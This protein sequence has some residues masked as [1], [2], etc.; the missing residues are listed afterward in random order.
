MI[1]CIISLMN[2]TDRL[3]EM[4]PSWTKIDK[5]KDF[6]IVDWC[7]KEPI[8]N[9]KIVQENLQKHNIKIIRVENENYFYRCQAWN[10]AF[11]YT[12]PENKILLKLDVDYVNINHSWLDCLKINNNELFDYFITGCYE[13]YPHS[14]GFLLINKKDFNKGYNENALPLWGF[15]DIDLIRRVQNDFKESQLSKYREWS[16]LQRVIFFNISQHI[17]HLPHSDKERLE[18]LGLY[19]SIL[20]KKIDKW[21]LALK[22][23]N[24]IKENPKWNPSEY[25]TLEESNNY[26]ILKRI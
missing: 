24:V 22:N 15:E 11:K 13:F 14:L 8:I 19:D 1:S 17:Y 26:V 21:S 2:R 7:S 16:G 20:D 4:L 23:G 3:E 12:N 10:L 18:N 6:V 5:I 25:K 9:N